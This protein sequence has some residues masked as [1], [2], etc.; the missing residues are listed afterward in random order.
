MIE[1]KNNIKVSIIIPVYNSSKYL[2]ECL[3]SC[4]NQTLKEIEIVVV[5]DGSTDNSLEIIEK[6]AKNDKRIKIINKKNEG[7][8]AA[9]N[10]AINNCNKS[11]FILFLDSDDYLELNALEILYSCMIEEKSDVIFF[12]VN[13]IFEEINAKNKCITISPYCARFKKSPFKIEEAYD[14]LFDTNALSFRMYRK[15]LWIEKNI[16]YTNHKL[17]EDALPYFEYLANS[18][19]ISFCEEHLYNYRKH[20]KSV[21][22]STQDK[23]NDLFEIFYL[24]EKAILKTKTGGFLIESYLNNRIRSFIFWLHSLPL[25]KRKDYYKKVRKVFLYIKN[26]YGFEKAKNS[27]FFEEFKKIIR[28]SYF[29]Y[30]FLNLTKTVFIILKSHFA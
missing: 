6:Y 13:W 16:K 4:I 25:N 27:E 20:P 23:V 11:E 21:T 15:K 22:A 17:A 26:K 1:N 18:K 12:N 8:G 9:R 5:N 3:T 29:K 30:R 14:I 10:F 7:A 2:D 19:I 28:L 24:C